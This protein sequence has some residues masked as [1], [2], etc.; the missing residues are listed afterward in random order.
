MQEKIPVTHAEGRQGFKGMRI[1]NIGFVEKLQTLFS[2]NKSVFAMVF[3]SILV[4]VVLVLNG[5]RALFDSGQDAPSYLDAAQDF[6]SYGWFSGE[7]RT[8]PLWPAGYPYFLTFFMGISENF[9]WLFVVVFQHTF[10][11]SAVL[12][13]YFSLR[14]LLPLFARRFLAGILLFMPTFLYSPSEN[15]YESVLFSLLLVATSAAIMAISNE[16]LEVRPKLLFICVLFYGM[17]GFIQPKTAPIGIFALLVIG[18]H[19]R[20]MSVA[21]LGPLALWGA[22]LLSFRSYIALGI[23]NPSTNF[24]L[25]IMNGGAKFQCQLQTNPLLSA[26][27]SSAS[28]DRQNTICAIKFFVTHPFDLFAHVAKQAHYLYGPID[29]GGI[30]RASTWFHGL[31]FIRI[32]E[33]LGISNKSLL[34]RIENIGSIFLNIAIICGFVI[35]FK[36]LERLKIILMSLPIV[37]ISFVHFVSLGD[38]R[39]R[40]PFIAFQMFFLTVFLTHI[41][42]KIRQKNKL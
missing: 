35:A 13:F 5:G 8:L 20:K 31:G 38:S 37:C 7:I 16:S 34:F 14:D 40:L 26:A 15:M 29:G 42:E 27:Q 4:R 36:R 18:F 17:A 11:I 25:A 9:W 24:G 41:I 23:I 39:Y 32:A 6:K 30:P 22:L 33:F 28:T 3:L 21:L 2:E 19:L 10:Y 1:A 12:Y